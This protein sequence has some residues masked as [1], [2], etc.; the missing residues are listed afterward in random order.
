MFDGYAVSSNNLMLG[1][2][3]VV[4]AVPVLGRD[5]WLRDHR[6]RPHR[7][8]K[9][10]PALRHHRVSILELKSRMRMSLSPIASSDNPF[11]QDSF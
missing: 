9:Q 5:R 8:E 2:L 11:S 4:M 7:E 1:E 6:R 10:T 3:V